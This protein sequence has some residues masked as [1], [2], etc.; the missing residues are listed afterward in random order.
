[1][2]THEE[3]YL[4]CSAHTTLICLHAAVTHE[5]FRGHGFSLDDW[6]QVAYGRDSPALKRK[7]SVV[8]TPWLRESISVFQCW[9]LLSLHL[10]Y[11]FES[12]G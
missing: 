2:F 5:V 11:F 12:V 1:M 8:S 9:F 7:C 4:S 3:L 6:V 10:G